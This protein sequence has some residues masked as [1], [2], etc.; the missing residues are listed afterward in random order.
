M[1]DLERGF[2][3]TFVVTIKIITSI[4]VSWPDSAYFLFFSLHVPL[5]QVLFYL[6]SGARSSLLL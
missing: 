5:S 1:L 6:L 2:E 4:Q 3:N